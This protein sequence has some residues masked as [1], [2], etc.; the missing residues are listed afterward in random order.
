MTWIKID[1]DESGFAT[2]E[3]LDKIEAILKQECDIL[4]ELVRRL[5]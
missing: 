3:C 1:R 4:V 2:E 5:K